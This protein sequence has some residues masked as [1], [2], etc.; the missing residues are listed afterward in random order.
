MP[1]YH[2]MLKV[3]DTN[4]AKHEYTINL[5]KDK[6]RIDGAYFNK[7]NT[8]YLPIFKHGLDVTGVTNNDWYMGAHAMVEEL[9]MFDNTP[10]V[11]GSAINAQIGF[12]TAKGTT[13]AP[14]INQ[15]GNWSAGADTVHDSSGTYELFDSSVYTPDASKN[16]LLQEDFASYYNIGAPPTPSGGGDIPETESWLKKNIVLVIVV[17]VVGFMV[18]AALLYCLCCKANK[19]G[20]QNAL[21]D[22]DSSMKARIQ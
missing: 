12:C 8:C 11:E 2:L 13:D 20:Y 21:Y 17:G 10:H 18:L 15:Y 1:L 3:H 5:N 16:P 22:E 14:A 6:W 7:P 19:H 4:A 9:L